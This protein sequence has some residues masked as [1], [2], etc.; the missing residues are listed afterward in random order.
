M[1]CNVFQSVKQKV[2]SQKKVRQVATKI[3]SILNKTRDTEFSIHIVGDQRMKALNNRY[4]NIN[5]TTDVLSFAT[6]G[7]QDLGDIFISWPQIKRQAKEF[8]VPIREEFFR[9]MVHGI[10]H[11]LGYDHKKAQEAQEMLTLQE[12]LVNKI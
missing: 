8:G 11:L 1:T 9:M 6:G 5:K 4:R 7:S 10:L 3:F 12:K 2:L